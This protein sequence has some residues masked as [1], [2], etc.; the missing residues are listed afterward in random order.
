MQIDLKKTDDGERIDNLRNELSKK[1][2][3][4]ERQ[5]WEANNITQVLENKYE[6]EIE[7]MDNELQNEFKLLEAKLTSDNVDADVLRYQA[8]DNVRTGIY[9]KDVICRSTKISPDDLVANLAKTWFDQKES[10]K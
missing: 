1:R 10:C 3:V 4:L 8:Y 6:M 2:V 7:S 5:I 9:S